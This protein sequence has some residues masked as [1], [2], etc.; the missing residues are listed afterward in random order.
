MLELVEN[1]LVYVPAFLIG[2]I[3]NRKLASRLVCSAWILGF[4]WLGYGVWDAYRIY[5]LNPWY[6][7]HEGT[8]IRFVWRSFFLNRGDEP[9]T[10][11]FFTFPALS[12]AVFSLGAWIALRHIRKH[13]AEG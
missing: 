6:P 12:S 11:A 8:F 3:L 2:W 4:L 9:L 13:R 5:R 10:V 1:A 7:L